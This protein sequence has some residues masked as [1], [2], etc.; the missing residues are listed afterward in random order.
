MRI[1]R[2]LFL[3]P[4][5]G[6]FITGCNP[7]N[8][9]ESAQLSTT[10]IDASSMEKVKQALIKK[11][12]DDQ[13][14]R[15]ERGVAQAAALWRNEDGSTADFADF[16]QAEFVGDPQQL[17]I[18]YNK[19]ERNME[20]LWG[21][22]HQ[23]DVALKEPLHLDGSPITPV[24]QMFGG[25]NASAHLTSDLFKTKVAFLTALNFPF[26]SL[27]EKTRLGENWT[28]QQ[29]AYARMG[30]V[31]TSRVPAQLKLK[32]SKT[33]TDAD[34]YISEYNVYMGQLV[35]DQQKTWFPEGMKLITHW[36]LRD[37]LKSNYSD[38]ANGL[39]KQ[40]MV[41][42]VMKRIID[43]SI[44]Q[45]MINRNDFQWNPESNK[46]YQN[47]QEVAFE[48][49]PDTR[50]RVL[51]DNFKVIRE[52]D[53]YYPAY[54]N[55]IQRRFEGNMEISQADVEQLFVDFV[56][57]PLVK[58]VGALI[59]ERLGR[60]LEPFDIWYDGFKARSG[61]SEEMLD[62]KLQVKY[63]NPAAL[64]KD[65]P[66][67][68]KKLGFESN[69]AR[70]ITD[71][72]VVDPSRGA[73]HAWGAEMHSDVSHLRTRIGANGMN[74]KG[75]NIAVHEFGHN[76]EQTITLH[77]VDY[78]MLHGV[79]NTAFTEA[80]AFIFQ[81]RD[82]DLLDIKDPNPSKAHMMA[83]DN[84]WSCYEIM[85]V[86][87]VDM[88]VW[89]WMYENPAAQPADLKEAVMRIAKDIW[90]KYY[91][92]VLGSKDEPI[93][94]IYSHMIDN[95]LYLSAYP[96]GHLIDF[97]IEEYIAGKSFADEIQRIYQQGRIVPQLWMQTAVGR[98]I[99]NE[100]TQNASQE[101]LQQLR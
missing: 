56:S 19:L 35:D 2:M 31:F 65:L 57:S 38:Q 27:E 23:I 12:G 30:D 43:Q 41:Y 76:V 62:Q 79:P 39:K 58:E 7:Q 13:Q 5:F 97:Q 16:C 44:P 34:T 54:D 68:L 50:Y 37:E 98:E 22:F 9:Q 46:L 11:Y 66:N 3:V 95:P 72:I 4:V 28:R 17:T 80:L 88:N 51:L 42:S 8:V 24:D 71:R 93:L 48:S 15:I 1:F 85:G 61:I 55:Y 33:L 36:G 94:G 101:A 26:Y 81:K 92:P 70:E 67:I 90:N 49:E 53:A 99:A 84:F 45:Q 100:P 89:K 47:G 10:N 73:G 52:Q 20:V 74:Y 86:S 83:L 82:L 75:Y 96:V 18:L 63:P 87:L 78:Y 40:Q 29:W 14:F 6:L 77:D 64:K 32:A 91:A 25:Y 59:Q 60:D 21:L 69:K